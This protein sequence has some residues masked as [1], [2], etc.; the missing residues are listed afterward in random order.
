MVF[1]FNSYLTTFL[2]VLQDVIFDC[3][4]TVNTVL[5]LSDVLSL[6]TSTFADYLKRH[7]W[8]RYYFL[9]VGSL[10]VFCVDL[11]VCCVEGRGVPTPAYRVLLAPSAHSKVRAACLPP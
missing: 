8:C 2:T 11:C 3:V 4:N 9:P 6:Q 10:Y 5:G 1:A 7:T